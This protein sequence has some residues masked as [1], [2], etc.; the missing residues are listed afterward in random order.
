[1]IGFD[2]ISMASWPAYELTTVRQPI[3]QM[4]DETATI[5]GF[6]KPAIK[7]QSTERRRGNWQDHPPAPPRDKC[8][9]I[10]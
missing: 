1:M 5:L 3:A 4:V 10:D 7:R 2:D 9:Q 8:D 6:D